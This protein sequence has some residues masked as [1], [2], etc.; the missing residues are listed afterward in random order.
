MPTDNDQHGKMQSR[1]ILERVS[2]EADSSSFAQGDIGRARPGQ[3]AAGLDDD[4]LDAWATRVGRTL[5]LVVTVA[6]MVWLVL[7]V[8]GKV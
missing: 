1:R 4:P 2:K 5:G 7:Y 8:L 3:S 6:I